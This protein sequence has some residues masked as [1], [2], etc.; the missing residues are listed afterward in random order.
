MSRRAAASSNGW[1]VVTTE[2]GSSSPRGNGG[3]VSPFPPRPAPFPFFLFGGEPIHPI[4]SSPHSPPVAR[5]GNRKRT[6][7]SA[8][9][10]GFSSPLLQSMS[11]RIRASSAPR[12]DGDGDGEGHQPGGCPACG[13]R[14]IGRPRAHDRSIDFSSRRRRCC[15]SK[16]PLFFLRRPALCAE[17]IHPPQSSRGEASPHL[18]PA[19]TT[20]AAR[21]FHLSFSS[22][23]LPFSSAASSLARSSVRL[24]LRPSVLASPPPAGSSASPD[25]RWPC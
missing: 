4:S 17:T 21:W 24:Q 9:H 15:S 23:F 18:D 13:D 22:F 19:A 14:S 25:D 11:G 1:L 6:A 16:N 10:A 8:D 3:K 2:R 12:T 5:L 7:H 20:L